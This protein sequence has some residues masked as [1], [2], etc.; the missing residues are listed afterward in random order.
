[1]AGSRAP[2]TCHK[3]LLA[4]PKASYMTNNHG[5]RQR[6]IG[7]QQGDNDDI[8]ICIWIQHFVRWDSFTLFWRFAKRLGKRLVVWIYQ[9]LKAYFER[10]VIDAILPMDGREKHV[11]GRQQLR[12]FFFINLLGSANEAYT[13]M[14]QWKPKLKHHCYMSVKS[15]LKPCYTVANL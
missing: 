13:N 12:Y 5:Q 7:I 6:L 9:S 2:P 11:R 14:L 4:G 1:M 8:I 3:C 15:C 10:M